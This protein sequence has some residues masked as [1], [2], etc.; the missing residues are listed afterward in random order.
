MQTVEKQK[1]PTDIEDSLVS[2]EHKDQDA[3]LQE[4]CKQRDMFI[5]AD[6]LKRVFRMRKNDKGE[7]END[8]VMK[9]LKLSGAI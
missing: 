6:V 2:A 8:D 1:A 7:Y 9:E 4:L 5:V 3:F